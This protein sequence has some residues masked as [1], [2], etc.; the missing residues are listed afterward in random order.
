MDIKDAIEAYEGDVFLYFGEISREGYSTLSNILELK[1][2]KHNKVCLI[3][4]T[5]GGDPNA[6]F[7]M[8]RAIGHHYENVEVSTAT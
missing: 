1:P 2:N 3:P 7:R 4:A 8:A 5:F 6:G